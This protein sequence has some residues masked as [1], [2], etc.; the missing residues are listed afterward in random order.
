VRRPLIV[1]GIVFLLVGLSLWYFPIQPVDTGPV[2]DGG[3]SF[4][5][6]DIAP[7]DLLGAHVPFTLT[8]ASHVGGINVSLYRCGDKPKCTGLKPS[9]YVTG[10][11][12]AS[13]TL[14]WTGTAGVYYVLVTTGKPL[15]VTIDY[16]QPVL[17]GTAGLVSVVFGG[18]MLGFGLWLVPPADAGPTGARKKPDDEILGPDPF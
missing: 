13:G 1:I 6:G 4:V 5:L 16:P 18:L 7:F 12:G 8:W 10:E 9:T 2:L 17:G 15:T 14:H 3:T 11:T